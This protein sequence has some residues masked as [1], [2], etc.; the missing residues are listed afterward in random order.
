VVAGGGAPAAFF[1]LLA[2]VFGGAAQLAAYRRLRTVAERAARPPAYPGAVAV[3]TLLAGGAGLVALNSVL[4]SAAAATGVPAFG[5]LSLLL[6]SLP[7]PLAFTG[8][9][10]RTRRAAAFAVLAAA[11]LGTLAWPVRA[12]QERIAAHAWFAE[13]PGVD[14]R[15]LRAVRWR[16][17]EQAPYAVVGAGVRATVFFQGSAVGA[18]DDAVIVIVPRSTAP[19][20]SI[21]VVAENKEDPDLDPVV[22]SAAPLSCAP[23]GPG[24]WTLLGPQG[25]R[26]YAVRRDGV[27]L[28]LS[29][30]GT[31]RPHDDLPAV[32]RTL[33][34]LD[35]H[36]LRA[37][38]APGFGPVW[39][40]L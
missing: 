23:V 8:F 29:V 17:G 4:T 10:F 19:C 14:R 2:T 40:L 22:R 3:G 28:T 38:V 20:R 30:N 27:L 13:H 7:Y 35:R 9:V 33:R 31:A 36:G 26:G 5:A 34:P 16:G 11:L 21:T 6:L 12:A 25:W 1:V 32:A 39:L 18:E 37:H 24:A 15:A